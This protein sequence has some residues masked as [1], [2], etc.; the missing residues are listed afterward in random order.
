MTKCQMKKGFF[1]LRE[2]EN[3]AVTECTVCGRQFCKDHMR[4]MPGKNQP[5]C[6]DCLGKQLQKSKALDKRKDNDY[7][8]YYYDPVWCYGYRHSYYRDH[9]YSP[10]YD[11]DDFDNDYYSDLDVR[12]FDDKGEEG[13]GELMAEDYDDNANVFDS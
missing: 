8:D 7:D 11:G 5:A 13:S 6:L 3:E 12:S 4:M 10:W 2:C 9:R 1:Y